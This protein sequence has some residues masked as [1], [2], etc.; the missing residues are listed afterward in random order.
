MLTARK[1]PKIELLE[2]ECNHQ[3]ENNIHAR[4]HT[5]THTHTH[6]DRYI[7]IYIYIYIYTHTHMRMVLPQQL[8]KHLDIRENR[9]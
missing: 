4:T 7:Y 5:H 8:K 6:T 3:E 2:K 1:I 9:K